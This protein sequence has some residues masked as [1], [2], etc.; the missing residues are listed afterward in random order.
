MQQVVGT[1]TQDFIAISNG[2]KHAFEHLFRK[3]YRSLCEYGRSI[4]SDGEIA[5]DVVQEVFICFWD[6]RNVLDIQVSVKSYLYTAVRYRA[7]NVLEKQ[8]IQRKH[9]PAL[10]EYVE[11]LATSEYS[12]E[13]QEEI[14]RIRAVMADLPKQCLKIFLMSALEGKK[15]QEIADELGVSLNTVKTHISRAYRLIREKI[16]SDMRL[17]LLIFSSEVY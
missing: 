1:D 16:S 10:A 4:L 7:L 17:V 14:N 9:N 3:Y 5:E 13:E 11:F 2:D 15:Y 12:E 8:L 6:H